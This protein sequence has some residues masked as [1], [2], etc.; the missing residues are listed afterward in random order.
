MTMFFIYWRNGGPRSPR[1]ACTEKNIEL[2]NGVIKCLYVRYSQAQDLAMTYN[3]N[4]SADFPQQLL[5]FR[6]IM[7]SKIESNATIK[8][9]AE[10]LIVKHSSIMT[11]VLDVVTVFKI[12]Y[13][14]L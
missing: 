13:Q 14:S 6:N 3:Q 2:L 10:L 9:L 7:M 1:S 12:F 4:L 11:S 5:A 8:D